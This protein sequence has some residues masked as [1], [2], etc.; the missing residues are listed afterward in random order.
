MAFWASSMNL[1]KNKVFLLIL[2][3][4]HVLNKNQPDATLAPLGNF[5]YEQKTKWPPEQS[6]QDLKY[7]ITS[8]I[9]IL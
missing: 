2:V 8:L 7:P 4:Q 5:F 1:R 9:F 6:E 3:L